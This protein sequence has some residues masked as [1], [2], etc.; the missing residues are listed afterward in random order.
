MHNTVSFYV[1]FVI[2]KIST[3]AI[4]YLPIRVHAKL[5]GKAALRSVTTSRITNG[6]RYY[7][8]FAG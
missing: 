4:G 8:L 5:H 6:R 2:D 1:V 7:S 3:S